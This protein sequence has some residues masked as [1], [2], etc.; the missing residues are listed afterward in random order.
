[1]TLQDNIAAGGWVDVKD[2]PLVS[3]ALVAVDGSTDV[4]CVEEE[5]NVI[6]TGQSYQPRFQV[7]STD[8]GSVNYKCSYILV[9]EYDFR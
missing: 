6:T 8:A 1:M 4:V 7:D 3:M 9:M 2:I 5:T